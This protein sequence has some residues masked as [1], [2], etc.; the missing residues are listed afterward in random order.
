MYFTPATAV[1]S[2]QLVP[3]TLAM[4]FHLGLAASFRY[5][6]YCA[7]PLAACHVT[8]MVLPLTLALPRVTLAGV[9]GVGVPGTVALTPVVSKPG[10]RVPLALMPRTV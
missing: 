10:L 5:T 6:R 1:L 9:V 4:P 3:V 7:A 8:T 2:V